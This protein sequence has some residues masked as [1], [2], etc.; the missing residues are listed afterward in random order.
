MIEGSD[1]DEFHEGLVGALVEDEEPDCEDEQGD[2]QDGSLPPLAGQED[3]CHG[4]LEDDE[5]EDDAVTDD[6]PCF[7]CGVL[8]VVHGVEKLVFVDETADDEVDESEE[9][10]EPGGWEGAV[11]DADDEN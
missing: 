8:T 3:P 6:G 4:E 11:D 5:T 7:A 1:G 2:D 10:D 9:E